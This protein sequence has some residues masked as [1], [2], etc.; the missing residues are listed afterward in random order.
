MFS[1]DVFPLLRIDK[2]SRSIIEVTPLAAAAKGHGKPVGRAGALKKL[3]EKPYLALYSA[4][5]RA[6]VCARLDAALLRRFNYTDC[7]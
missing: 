2:K 5:D 1:E 7:L 4:A 3:R 6:A